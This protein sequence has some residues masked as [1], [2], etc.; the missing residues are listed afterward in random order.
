MAGRTLK[1][2]DRIKNQQIAMRLPR[3]QKHRQP[4]GLAINFKVS[5]MDMKSIEIRIQVTGFLQITFAF[6]CQSGG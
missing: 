1:H 6:F 2:E 5:A 4:D 3:L